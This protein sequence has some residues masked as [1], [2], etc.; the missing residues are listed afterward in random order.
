MMRVFVVLNPVAGRSQAGDVRRA[1]GRYFR[2]PEWELEIFETTGA[3]SI[4]EIV[5]E[6]VDRGTCWVVAAGG[7][8]TVS[9]VVDG[10]IGRDG[11]LGILPT[12]SGNVIAQELGIP[13][14]LERALQL[15]IEKPVIR[16]LDVIEVNGSYYLLAVGTGVDALA[17]KGTSRRE[18]R[19][20]GPVAYLWSVLKVILGV[21]PHRFTLV[22]DGRKKRVRAADILLSNVGTLTW[23]LRWSPHIK[24]DDGQIDIGIMRASGLLD[25]FKV[26]WDVIIPG[27]PRHDR[28]LRYLI[29]RETVE[30]YADQPLPVQGDG[31]VLGHT[32]IK[33]SVLPGAVRVLVP[34]EEQKNKWLNLPLL[35]N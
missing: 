21:Q 27:R 20:F 13:L 25:F 2:G 4:K 11:L 16:N 12:G 10:L 28:N 5:A 14:R 29:A 3:E 22:V 33:A 31:E 7:D 26:A 8:G 17:I 19:R 1:L 30:V 23:P 32:P 34:S 9:A 24:P 6:A 15:L 35:T 18:K